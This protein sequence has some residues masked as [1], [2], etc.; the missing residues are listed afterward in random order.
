MSF[1]VVLV[2]VAESAVAR[3]FLANTD[4]FPWELYICGEHFTAES[5]ASVHSFFQK[6]SPSVV[7]SLMT[8]PGDHA[9]VS[10]LKNIAAV[11]GEMTIPILHQSSY[12]AIEPEH[13]R[14]EVLESLSFEQHPGHAEFA[15]FERIAASVPKHIILRSS[16]ILDGDSAG[17]FA[18]LVPALLDAQEGLV[19]SDH[20]FGAPVSCA[21]ICDA[22]VALIQQVLTGSDNWGVYH[23]HSADTCSEAEFCDHLVRQLQKE[24]EVE[25]PF[26]NV[27]SMDDDRR[28]F[29]M[30]A[31]LIGRRITD[32]FGVQAPT[33]RRG[34]ARLLREWLERHQDEL[35]LRRSE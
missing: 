33:W 28:F 20:D 27:A 25:L 1:R 10:S 17:L 30:N 23:L 32:D 16:W 22:M 14:D 8:V 24:L 2:G 7:I 34:F 31:N 11:C 29:S 5:Q 21:Y 15:N 9:P 18:G 12:W 35:G 6:K 3:R 13:G 4:D 26:P 19:V